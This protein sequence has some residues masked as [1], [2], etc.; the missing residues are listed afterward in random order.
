[1][2]RKELLNIVFLL[3]FCCGIL[4][5]ILPIFVILT[6]WPGDDS[7]RS[8]YQRGPPPENTAAVQALQPPAFAGENLSITSSDARS[9][10]PLAGVEYYLNGYFSGTSATDGSFSVP[11]AG[12]PS[13]TVSVRAV[14]EGYQEK[15]VRFDFTGTRTLVLDLHPY[16]IIPVL[17][18]GPRDSRIDVVFLPSDTAMN[19]TTTTKVQLNGYPGGQPQFERDVIRFINETFDMYPSNLSRV[20]PVSGTYADKFNFYYYWDGETYADAFN[21]CSGTIPAT[22]WQ[23]VTFSDLTIILY[24][25]VFGRYG[26]T[27]SQPAGCTNP[28]GL[29]RVYLKIGVGDSYLGIH[30]IGH[31]LYGLMDTYCGKSYYIENSLNPNIWSSEARCRAAALANNWNPDNCR[32][33]RDTGNNCINAFWRWDPDP[34]IMNGGWSGK[35]GN[36]STRRIADTLNRIFA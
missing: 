28:Q 2:Q 20:Y 11:A 6:G 7:G 34:D 32:Q 24:T 9:R 23:N 27:V 30:E 18:S 16:G 1:M 22:Y 13:G 35:F 29:G 10:A 3:L 12:Y 14:K 36:A 8:A 33:I 19:R 15:T 26:G 21:G 5:A 4:F 25:D 31:G 17:V